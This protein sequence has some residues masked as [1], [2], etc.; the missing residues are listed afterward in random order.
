MIDLSWKDNYSLGDNK[1]DE[2]HKYLFKIAAEAFSV[3]AP[4]KKLEKIKSVLEKL[5]Q[6]TKSHFDN[7][8][9]F[10]SSI[11]YPELNKHKILHQEII[12]SMNEFIKNI[13]N[14][15]ISEIEKDLAYNI[16]IWFISHIV[17]EDKRITQ[18]INKI[19]AFT[20]S[21]KSSYRIG[22]TTID[23]EHQELFQIASEAFK[24]VPKNEKLKKIKSTLSKL[25]KYF[26]QHFE[27]EEKYMLSLNYDKL[28]NHKIIHKNIMETLSAL[29]KNSSKMKIKEIE[30]ELSSFI[31]VSLVN[32]IIKEDRK[33][34]LWIQFLK[35]LEEA[36][37]FKEL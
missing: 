8:E 3:V 12:I 16:K 6:Y 21:W 9:S 7:E 20:F 22:D 34:S 23:A 15:K 26:Q 24:K 5:L 32:H 31:E 36:K 2:E 10:M 27:N 4:D 33:I 1:I 28:D 14:M 18:W 17:Y 19:P 30:D 35:D 25:F 29:I 13:P 37:K 11:K